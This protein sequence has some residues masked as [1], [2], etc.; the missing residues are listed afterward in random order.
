MCICDNVLIS[1]F[2]STVQISIINHILNTKWRYKITK[3]VYDKKQ[4]IKN[5]LIQT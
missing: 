1:D 2:I 5:G 3:T 4:H